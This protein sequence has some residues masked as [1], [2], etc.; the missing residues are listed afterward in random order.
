MVKIFKRLYPTRDEIGFIVPVVGSVIGFGVGATDLLGMRKN[1]KHEPFTT[2]KS[3][4]VPTVAGALIIGLWPITV[5]AGLITAIII[6][7]AKCPGKD[8]GDKN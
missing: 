7:D 6:R 5:P 8:T 3:I 1:R 4:L 2:F